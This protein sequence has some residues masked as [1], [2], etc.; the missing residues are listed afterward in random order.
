MLLQLFL[1]V[2]IET[3]SV[4]SINF[5]MKVNEEMHLSHKNLL[6]QQTCCNC[7]IILNKNSPEKNDRFIKGSLHMLAEIILGIK[8]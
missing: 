8:Q 1:L 3:P 4:D 5:I 2:R 7:P 6:Y